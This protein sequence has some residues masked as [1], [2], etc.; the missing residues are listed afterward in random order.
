[1]F[2]RVEARAATDDYRLDGWAVMA[3]AIG[4]SKST[5]RRYAQ[6]SEGA[7]IRV[8]SSGDC[9]FGLAAN[10]KASSLFALKEMMRDRTSAAR[11][12]AVNK[13]WH[14]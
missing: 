1:M 6:T 9:E 7:V 3:E 8:S 11:R 13:R 10:C 5:L 14:K 4:V 2:L 12:A